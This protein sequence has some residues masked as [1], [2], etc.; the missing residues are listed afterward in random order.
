L[1]YNITLGAAEPLN[2][3]VTE[4]A[5][6]GDRVAAYETRGRFLPAM[7]KDAGREYSLV[8]QIV[9]PATEEG[10]YRWPGVKVKVIKD[11]LGIFEGV[12]ELFWIRSKNDDFILLEVRTYSPDSIGAPTGAWGMPES[13]GGA[14]S[15]IIF[16]GGAAG[17]IRG[18]GS[19]KDPDDAIECLGF[20]GDNLHFVRNVQAHKSDHPELD[21]KSDILSQAFEEHTWFA[22][23]K[24][25]VRLEQHINGVTSMTWQLVGSDVSP[26]SDSGMV[27]Q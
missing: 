21:G 19:G 18:L 15:R 17:V 5:L 2:F 7:N 25:M 14:S 3:G 24:G 10:P 12:Q 9:G 22:R 27:T 13:T 1:E 26:D 8:L 23:G 11:E 6:G 4:W 20:D 16:F